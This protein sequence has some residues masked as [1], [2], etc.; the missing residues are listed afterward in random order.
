L[1]ALLK[2][3]GEDIRVVCTGLHTDGAFGRTG[4]MVGYDYGN[5]L[6]DLVLEEGL[7]PGVDVI[8]LGQVD[9]K[10]LATLYA[11]SKAVIVPSFAE[12]CSLPLLEGA[13]FKK[14]L[15][16]SRIPAHL[17]MADFYGIEP[18]LFDPIDSS[19]I[20][21]A[22]KSLLRKSPSERS[23]NNACIQVKKRNYEVV[24]RQYMQVFE[25]LL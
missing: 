22:V 13:S 5:T 2:R 9:D 3:D 8:G 25:S 17:E 15:V 12:G 18:T 4:K 16:C 1:I 20:A 19:S 11:C 24:A 14:P 6:R 23:L 21:E 10:C 7:T